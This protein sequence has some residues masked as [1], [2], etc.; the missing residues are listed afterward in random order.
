MICNH[1]FVNGFDMIIMIGVFNVDHILAVL[2][3]VWI[4]VFPVN[5]WSKAQTQHAQGEEEKKELE[6][7]IKAGAWWM[8]YLGNP[9]VHNFRLRTKITWFLPPF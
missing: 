2:T 4:L 6:D 3:I 1:V 5:I 8:L 7:T 9:V